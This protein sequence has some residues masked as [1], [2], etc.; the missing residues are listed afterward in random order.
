VKI[1]PRV[2]PLNDHHKKIPPVVQIL[3]AHWRLKFVGVLVDPV[4]KINRRLHSRHDHSVFGH[5]RSVKPRRYLAIAI[6]RKSTV[7]SENVGADSCYCRRNLFGARF[8]SPL[9]RSKSS[10][11]VKQEAADS[12]LGLDIW[13]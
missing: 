4:F 8:S 3:I 10:I 1:V 9:N 6:V 13:S 2:W 12:A 7:V 11:S 5:A